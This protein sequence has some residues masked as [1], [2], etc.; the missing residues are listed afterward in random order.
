MFYIFKNF[1]LL[2][3]IHSFD[4]AVHLEKPSS[5]AKEINIRNRKKRGLGGLN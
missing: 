4:Q 3:M 5:F 1:T 2:D